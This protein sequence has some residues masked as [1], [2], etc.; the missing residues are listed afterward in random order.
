MSK[1]RK[2][3]KDYLRNVRLIIGAHRDHNFI[4]QIELITSFD[5]TSFILVFTEFDRILNNIS[6]PL[7]CVINES[8]ENFVKKQKPLSDSPSAP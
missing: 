8:A 4:S 1:F 3:H 5:V 6:V 7:Q 2:D